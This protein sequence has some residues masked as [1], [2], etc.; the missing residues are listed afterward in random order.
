VFI[1]RLTRILEGLVYIILGVVVATI[2]LMLFKYSPSDD[3][4][5]VL[6]D[7]TE[8]SLFT[9][10]VLLPIPF[11]FNKYLNSPNDNGLKRFLSKITYV[12]KNI[13]IALG[14]LYIG[15]RILHVEI[16]LLFESIKWN[17]ESVTSTLLSI[18]LIPTIIYGILR[19][20]DSDKHRIIHRFF[21]ALT[22]L[23]FILHL[24]H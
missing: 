15:M 12:L 1:K 17:M 8:I 18:L 24:F 23:V 4:I 20:K 10:L 2:I 9:I 6:E 13:H 16:N 3:L 5:G 14:I 22:Y 7:I 21:I 19:I 11:I